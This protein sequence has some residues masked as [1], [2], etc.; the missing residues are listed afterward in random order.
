MFI[1]TQKIIKKQNKNFSK[2]L[3]DVLVLFD[4]AVKH[5]NKGDY[6][7]AISVY[8][9][10]VEKFSNPTDERVKQPVARAL[11]N[12]GRLLRRMK[13]INE[14]LNVYNDILTKFGEEEYQSVLHVVASAMNHKA[15][16]LSELNRP[17][18][19]FEAYSWTIDK[20]LY[21][22]FESAFDP[23]N[24][25]I[26][27]GIEKEAAKA[28]LNQAINYNQQGDYKKTEERCI[29]LF[30]FFD[31][32]GKD[33]E[34]KEI[35]FESLRLGAVA[36]AQNGNKE[37]AMNASDR[38][39]KYAENNPKMLVEALWTRIVVLVLLN[40]PEEIIMVCDQLIDTAKGE[41]D[42]DIRTTLVRALNNKDKSLIRI[43]N[44]AH[45]IKILDDIIQYGKDIED[46]EIQ[47]LVAE[48]FVNKAH[49]LISRKKYK[50]AAAVYE[51]SIAAFPNPK[52]PEIK[53]RLARV[54]YNKA[55]ALLNMN[56][57]NK[58]LKIYDLILSMCSGISHIE[59]LEVF[60]DSLLG[61]GLT[62]STLGKNQ[63][64]M[65][66][67]NKLY[68]S[69]RDSKHTS[70]RAKGVAGVKFY[71]G[72]L[73]KCNQ[74]KEAKKIFEKAISEFKNEVDEEII[75]EYDELK[76]FLEDLKKKQ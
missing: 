64:A 43:D 11:F 58:V 36:S 69:F 7:K 3:N 31:H 17:A 54:L 66:T 65:E 55:L 23:E 35:G 27:P 38:A 39:V 56:Q 67:F 18:E 53:A 1:K 48:A 71:G 25:H 74:E 2:E 41:E 63:K 5:T 57:L 40:K 33:E 9:C 50:E 49:R 62:Y 44:N 70:L 47:K 32:S 19:Q 68:I 21:L 75:K 76:L 13:K 42:M 37:E 60:A 14:A 61:K 8:D 4:E 59:I 12:K 51:S 30:V 6:D 26:H 22:Y 10:L 73:S 46:H 52:H 16:V 20:F 34:L 45:D 24:C 15:T 29:C 72:I 28:M